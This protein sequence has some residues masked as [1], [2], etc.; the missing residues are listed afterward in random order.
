MAGPMCGIDDAI[1]WIQTKTLKNDDM[2]DRILR[3]LEYI[4]NKD[5]GVKPKFHK[6]KS[7]HDWWTCGNCGHIVSEIGY[8]YCP[9][10]GYA[11]KWDSC[12]CLTG[13]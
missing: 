6:G 9:E 8:N 13:R 4:R 7:I 1:E 11:I 5:V 12:R 3:R 10:C 2:P